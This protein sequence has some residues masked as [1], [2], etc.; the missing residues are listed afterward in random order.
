M[1]VH[2]NVNKLAKPVLI[3]VSYTTFSDQRSAFSR[4]KRLQQSVKGPTP[5]THHFKID[6]F[7]LQPLESSKCGSNRLPSTCEV[8]RIQT[9]LYWKIKQLV[10]DRR[11]SLI[12]FFLH[13]NIADSHMH[14]LPLL[15]DGKL[16]RQHCSRDR[17]P[18]DFQAEKVMYEA[19]QTFILPPEQEESPPERGLVCRMD[20]CGSPCQQICVL[21]QTISWQSRQCHR[22]VCPVEGR[23]N[24]GQLSL[25]RHV[26]AENYSSRCCLR[27]IYSKYI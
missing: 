10:K 20:I 17:F 12:R 24:M 7:L 22:R 3:C 14:P 5:Q 4:L 1:N 21:W 15:P 18:H 26:S 9:E 2:P 6:R 19:C 11:M 8:I 27:K 25:A 23:D 16:L 13:I